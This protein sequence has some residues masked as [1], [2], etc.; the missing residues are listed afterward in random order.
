MR[1]DGTEGFWVYIMASRRN[2]TL[3]I[4]HTDHLGR[5]VH[6]HAHGLRPGFTRDYGCRILVWAE[7]HESARLL[8]R[9]NGR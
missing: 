4:G 3:Y 7:W 9:A 1:D 5:R 2:G 6:E 8:L